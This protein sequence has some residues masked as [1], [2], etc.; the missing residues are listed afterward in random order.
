MGFLAPIPLPR[1][2]RKPIE[3]SAVELNFILLPPMAVY[4]ANLVAI[5]G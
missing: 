3:Q 5:S 1:Q 4:K 2:N